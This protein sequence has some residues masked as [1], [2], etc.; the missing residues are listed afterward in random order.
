M[1]CEMILPRH[2][3]VTNEFQR[4]FVRALYYY[5]LEGLPGTSTHIPSSKYGKAI[6]KPPFQLDQCN[7]T[8]KGFSMT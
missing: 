5:Y 4:R 8:K 2:F 7:F 3:S 6:R 1:T